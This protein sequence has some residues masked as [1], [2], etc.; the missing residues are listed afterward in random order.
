VLK[1]ELHQRKSNN[2][3]CEYG[4]FSFKHKHF[5]TVYA[6]LA[7]AHLFVYVSTK[8][9]GPIKGK[10]IPL[11]AVSK[12]ATSELTSLLSTRYLVNGEC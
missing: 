4:Y 7:L 11:S 5:K 9:E 10:G 3:V 6:Y 2:I 8:R 12:D 1:L